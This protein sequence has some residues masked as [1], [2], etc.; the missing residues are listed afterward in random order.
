MYRPTQS[1]WNLTILD[2]ETVGSMWILLGNF[3]VPRNI[4]S[5][6]VTFYLVGFVHIFGNTGT[7]IDPGYVPPRSGH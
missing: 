4:V 6:V 5:V 2:L 3:L 7:L 1:A